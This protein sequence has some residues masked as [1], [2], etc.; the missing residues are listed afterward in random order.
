M[1]HLYLKRTIIQHE[2]IQR[3]RRC[4]QMTKNVTNSLFSVKNNHRKWRN[5]VVFGQDRG[6]KE[7]LHYYMNEVLAE[8]DWSVVLCA[9]IYLHKRLELW[10]LLEAEG[11]IHMMACALICAA[12]TLTHCYT[13]APIC[14]K[15]Q[16]APK[17]LSNEATLKFKN[18]P[19][20]SIPCQWATVQS[21]NSIE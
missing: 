12:Y 2:Q 17:N 19:M 3:R 10:R 21:K 14:S 20:R 8:S 13:Y 6:R 4:R 15:V 16:K 9:E 1:D 5:N 7:R 18:I 11:L